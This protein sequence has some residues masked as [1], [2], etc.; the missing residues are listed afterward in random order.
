MLKLCVFPHKSK[1]TILFS[2]NEFLILVPTF[3]IV[4]QPMNSSHNQD[5]NQRAK[6]TLSDLESKERQSLDD[7]KLSHSRN[8]TILG[9]RNNLDTDMAIFISRGGSHPSRRSCESKSNLPKGKAAKTKCSFWKKS[10]DKPKRALSAYNIF[11][12]H[13]RTRIINGL[14]DDGCTPEEATR[15]AI[16]AIIANSAKPRAPRS[17]RKTHGKIGFGDLARKIGSQWR[18]LDSEQRAIYEHYASLDME[19]YRS[20]VSI[21]KE[22]KEREALTKTISGGDAN[23]TQSKAES[24]ET[25]ESSFRSDST[26]S[27]RGVGRSDSFANSVDSQSSSD[28][29]DEWISLHNRAPD[30]CSRTASAQGSNSPFDP[31][32]SVPN[33]QY[34]LDDN[35]GGASTFDNEFDA[36]RNR[37]SILRVKLTKLKLE[38]EL[39]NEMIN[40]RT[41]QISSKG[42]S[43]ENNHASIQI[44]PSIERM[45]QL[46]LQRLRKGDNLPPL[47]SNMYNLQDVGHA[48]SSSSSSSISSNNNNNESNNT[49]TDV[50]NTK[51]ETSLDPVPFDEIFNPSALDF[52]FD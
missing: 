14:P 33:S 37:I 46:H 3:S 25:S 31:R 34:Q 11:F 26:P 21:W 45:Q 38:Q 12:K 22:K 9:N 39:K 27:E 44:G 29:F 16:E 10:R 5:H 40:I 51:Q 1:I 15:A 41:K 17:N 50:H 36:I 4:A 13:T 6:T 47:G 7:S 2:V 32:L 24:R 42:L 28:T 52:F 30:T 43:I 49:D 23:N 35:Q 8:S 20:E 18:A 19:R 48:S